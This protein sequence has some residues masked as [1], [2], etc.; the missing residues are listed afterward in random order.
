MPSA[1]G[2]T[3]PTLYHCP[4]HAVFKAMP[5]SSLF[6]TWAEQSLEGVCAVADSEVVGTGSEVAVLRGRASRSP[7]VFVRCISSLFMAI[8][9]GA[10]ETLES[11]GR[12]G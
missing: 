9:V 10:T 12:A 8:H 6:Q 4:H 3:V 2:F 1:Q 5:L 11:Q 7:W